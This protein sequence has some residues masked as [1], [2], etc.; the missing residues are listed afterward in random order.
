[1]EAATYRNNLRPS[2]I[3]SPLLV[4]KWQEMLQMMIPWPWNAATIISA[5]Q[6]PIM[7]MWLQGF[8][9]IAEM[10]KTYHNYHTFSTVIISK[11]HRTN[12][13][14]S[15]A[16]CT[17][18]RANKHW[19]LNETELILYIWNTFILVQSKLYLLWKRQSI[20]NTDLYNQQ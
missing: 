12:G 17:Y 7:I 6:L 14:N 2:L 11:I 4:L 10:L 3:A 5:N 9:R 13:H 19:W 1:M 8:R 18:M 15:R 20:K 16:T